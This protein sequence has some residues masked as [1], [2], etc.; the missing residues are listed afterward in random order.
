MSFFVSWLY[1]HLD[2]GAYSLNG[3][4]H[5]SL[6]RGARLGICNAPEEKGVIAI[7]NYNRFVWAFLGRANQPTREVGVAA[8]SKR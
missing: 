7:A 5:V 4:C 6:Y 8:K 3:L 2:T 1:V